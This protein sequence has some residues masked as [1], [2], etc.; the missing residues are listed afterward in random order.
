MKAKK[1]KVAKPAVVD[2]KAK[3]KVKAT[4]K[5]KPAKVKKEKPPVTRSPVLEARKR[6]D[7]LY[8]LHLLGANGEALMNSSQGY[9]QSNA[10]RASDT[11]KTVM[12]VA[13]FRF[14]ATDPPK[15]GDPGGEQIRPL[16][17]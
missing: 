6:K 9:S 12:Q 4:K 17:P 1:S 7:G 3:T 15:A 8:D 10:K 13:R 2:D 16:I 5:A 11:V 14:E